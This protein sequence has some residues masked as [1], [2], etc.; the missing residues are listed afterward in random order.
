[1]TLAIAPVGTAA[2]AGNVSDPAFV[3]VQDSAPGELTI[4][5]N[6]GTKVGTGV[7][8]STYAIRAIG[9]SVDYDGDGN[10]EVPYTQDDGTNGPALKVVDVETGTVDVLV[11]DTIAKDN[12]LAVGDWDADGNPDIFY[13]THSNLATGNGVGRVDADT[14]PTE[15]IQNDGEF[16]A[17]PKAYMGTAD[18]TGDGVRDLVWFDDSS[19]IKYTNN[20]AKNGGTDI[21]KLDT[22]NT[23]GSGANAGVGEPVDLDDDGK[24]RF[25]VIDSSGYPALLDL[26]GGTKIRLG[27]NKAGE[28]TGVATGDFYGDSREEL[29][30]VDG[31]GT[32]RYV[33]T[34]DSNQATGDIE[35]GGNTY[36]ARASEGIAVGQTTV[37]QRLDSL[38][39]TSPTLDGATA[40]GDNSYVEVTFSEGAYANADGSGGLSANDFDATLSQN[41]GSA[42]GVT[43]DS[44]TDT[45][46]A[47]T[48]GGE[49]TVRL[50]VTVSNGP[51]SGD[52]TVDVA[53]A[54]GSA[55]YDSAGNA[56]SSSA[57]TTATLSDR[58]APS[59]PASTSPSDD[60]DGVAAD[61]A[62]DLTFAED[63]RAGTG[64][65]AI[66]QSS[67]DATV[68]SVDVTS[69]QVTVSGKTLT[70]DPSTTLDGGTDYYV[71]VDSGAVTDTAGNA[72]AGFTDPTTLN[73]T[74]ADT[75]VPTVTG[76]TVS[77]D[78]SYV[79]VTFSEGVYANADGT[80]GLTAANLTATLSG[81]SDGSVSGVSVD[82][83]TRTDGTDATGGESTV[84]ASLSI[85]GT[86]SGDESVDIQPTDGRSVYDAVGNAMS[87]TESTGSLS[88][89]DQQAP[90]FSAGPSTSSV[91]VSGFDIDFTAD[92]SG[93]GY[94]VVV[95]DG[96]AA[97]SVSQVKAGVDGNGNAP[98]DSGSG[99]ISAGV[100][101]TFSASGLSE[102]TS[103]DVY[104]VA[105]DGGNAKLAPKLDQTTADTT[106]PTVT[107]GTV[108]SDNSYVDVTF[109]E[110]V[111]ENADG[112]GGLVAGDFEATQSGDS[113][114][115]VSGVSVD[116]VTRTDGSSTT[117]GETTLRVSLSVSG[118]A[119]GD[120]SIDVGPVDG[121]AIYDGAGNA[122]AGGVTVTTTLSDRQAPSDPASSSPTDG[123]GGVA[124][125]T[126]IELTFGEDVQTG[127]G[128]IAVKSASDDTT[129][130]SIDVTTSRV[131]ASS[132]TIT[133][134]PTTTLDGA[135]DY[136]V[137]VDSG[138]VMDTAGNAYAGF[139]DSTTL[140][141]TTADVTAPTVDALSAT[142]PTGRDVTVT[143]ESDEQLA[144]VTADLKGPESTTLSTGAFS[145]A[146]DGDT[147]TYT[148]TYGASSDGD[149]TTAL[150]AAVDAAGNDGA[151]GQTDTV[152]VDTAS[153]STVSSSTDDGDTS[154]PNIDG[155]AASATN[156]S[157]ELTV[158]SDVPLAYVEATLD[159]PEVATLTTDAFTES[160]RVFGYTYTTRY[161]PA[162]GGEYTAE[163][164]AATDDAGNDGADG[165]STTATVESVVPPEQ[166]TL[167]ETADGLRVSVRS[168]AA[169]DV[170]N[171]SVEGPENA[172]RSLSTFDATTTADGDTVYAATVAVT[173][174]GSYTATLTDAT[175]DG[176]PISTGQTDTAAVAN[177]FTLDPRASSND[178]VVGSNV[179]LTAGGDFPTDAK[180]T[181]EWDLDDDGEGDRSG[182]TV[183][184]AFDEPGRHYVDLV[185]VADGRTLTGS[186]TVSVRNRTG[187]KPGIDRRSLDFG[188]VAVG[189]T[190]R[191][192]L[193]VYNPDSS[194]TGYTISSSDLVGET[195]GAFAVGS[196]F[197]VTLEP[198]ERHTIPVS[199]TP[200]S[201]GDKQAQLQLLP[202]APS[203]PQL[204]VWLSSERSYILVQEV[205]TNSSVNA[206]VSVDAF[207]VD[208]DGQLEINVSQPGSRRQAVTVDE[209]GMVTAGDDTFDMAITHAPT[210]MSAV[211][212]PAPGRQNLQYIRLTH[213]NND[214]L[215]FA[216]TAV[217][218]RV[219]RRAL[220]ESTDPGAVEFSRWNG[221]A[222]N[223]SA[224]GTLVDRTA[225]HYVYRVETPGFSQFVVTGPTEDAV[226]ADGT[227]TAGPEPDGGETPADGGVTTTD[228]EGLPASWPG[229]AV[230][231]GLS[232]VLLLLFVLRRRD[233]DETVE[234]DRKP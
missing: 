26:A 215:R 107:G 100:Q 124:N 165:Q 48:T 125:D 180:P 201:R 192:N 110:S 142:N 166:F 81:D 151:G 2:A 203:S 41:G 174:E 140:N 197:P 214:S 19:A 59:D 75:A 178:V 170:L 224:T 51:A 221:T 189:E 147:Y 63:I 156:G 204:T 234:D 146:V 53:P 43:V 157:V 3:Y 98:A 76:G 160:D 135:T 33:E 32:V 50:Q 99:S 198:G 169:L 15:I 186:V 14:S 185:A 89:A 70:A 39:S 122:M 227:T 133:A 223:F 144:T 28:K 67:D 137:T 22:S 129:V 161:D 193:T 162:I 31:S 233:E 80:G 149:Y 191:M 55:I 47:A 45:G 68:E 108:S 106:A 200:T 9:P 216:D 141:F 132:K 116:G 183:T 16:D 131:S 97:P 134:D 87:D 217:R 126:T 77:S 145:E 25:P 167:S 176:Q 210:P 92:E 57:T 83:V 86:P 184:A 37:T 105:D 205:S 8:E 199:F 127:S 73:F 150:T 208:T 69:Q 171:V 194:G 88:L 56:M 58:Q 153:A 91:G 222:W 179:T 118:T 121:S 175:V 36:N 20:S 195:P 211:H 230:G 154:E 219:D 128:A 158:R 196:D 152:T 232:A 206:T 163:L 61:A 10:L 7:D 111:Y 225:T 187:P 96:A 117:G 143:V 188:R 64:A 78:N 231:G 11:K 29:V 93:T 218:Y 181:Y 82:A 27:D 65:I 34:T 21:E 35:I 115:S 49:R 74:T 123:A 173:T 114:G 12:K 4:V 202:A 90:S 229:L 71:T 85:S 177:G 213:R 164:T 60:A 120:E 228:S 62:V 17:K 102:A 148:A 79:D 24:V 136:Y 113:D 190:V 72:Y 40:V 220:P 30:Y 5:A 155:F 130:E 109:S 44:V 168:R 103:Y 182:R 23:P 84:R 112:T 95:D 101:T 54:D 212:E 38:D 18:V 138:A 207:N 104:V 159:G 139:T 94:Y 42:T 6:D 13:V 52:E 66:K 209:L 119:S 1:M 46:G 172:T 226:A